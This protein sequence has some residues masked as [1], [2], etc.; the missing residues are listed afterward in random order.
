M[1]KVPKSLPNVKKTDETSTDEFKE[2]SS[3]TRSEKAR[4]AWIVVLAFL[5]LA[6]FGVIIWLIFSGRAD[7]KIHGDNLSI[8]MSEKSPEDSE[9][10]SSEIDRGIVVN[11]TEID[12]T[13][14]D[15]NITIT[16]SGEHVLTGILNYSVLVDSDGPVSLALNGVTISSSETAAIINFSENPLEV[17]LAENS[18]NTIT[19][20]GDSA[21][22][23]ALFS[24][25]PL[26]ISARGDEKTLGS[27]IV[28]GRQADGEGI[29]TKNADLTIKSGKIMINS[30]SVGLTAGGDNG[31]VVVESG[32]LWVKAGGEGI[33]AN[34]SIKINGGN[35]L[36]MSTAK[37]YSALDSDESIING[38][39]VVALAFDTSEVSTESSAQ[40]SLSV[41]LTE[42][43]P[44]GS[45]VY[46]KNLSTNKV[47]NFKTETEF[48]TL[49][50]S[51]SS[52][53]TGDYEISIDG[54]TIGTG[55]VK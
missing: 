42:T 37:E 17:I 8:F 19:D 43:V 23:S 39:N 3:E 51:T 11:D 21:Y 14:Y 13:N 36:I 22:N 29:A 6:S 49:V 7:Q 50:F 53:E 18:T 52:V 25:G 38:G 32:I 15:S 44:A 46:V 47:V 12:L 30:N 28:S 9:D 34:K 2:N 10:D 55:V 54:R 45:T 35:L 40:K 41:E 48:R 26:A 31:T 4:L 27:L 5:L 1:E 24:N 33:F 20:G 16:A